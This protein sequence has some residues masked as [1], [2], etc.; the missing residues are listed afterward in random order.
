MFTFEG[1][2]TDA[3][4]ITH[5][6]PVFEIEHFN[7]QSNSGISG[8]YSYQDDEHSSESFEN[9]SATS[10]LMFVQKNQRNNNNYAFEPESNLTTQEAILN[11]CEYH[12]LAEILPGFVEEVDEVGDE[13]SE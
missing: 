7:Y 4:G 9:S 5:T 13:Q 12:F 10:S 11:A 8:N 1:T 2:I 6:N 3:Y